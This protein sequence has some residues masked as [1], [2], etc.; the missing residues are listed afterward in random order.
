MTGPSWSM[1]SDGQSAVP[2]SEVRETRE[3][4]PP[5]PPPETEK[6]RQDSNNAAWSSYQPERPDMSERLTETTDSTAPDPSGAADD[7]SN[8]EPEA[9][10]PAELWKRS[11]GDTEGTVELRSAE[12]TPSRKETD[13]AAWGSYRPGEAAGSAGDDVA[14]VQPAEGDEI[15]AAPVEA[16]TKQPVREEAEGPSGTEEY[17]TSG[18]EGSSEGT[19]PSVGEAD[20]G[21][22][23]AQARQEVEE[24]N[25]DRPPEQEQMANDA[26]AAIDA[27]YEARDVELGKPANA[28]ALADFREPALERFQLD[29]ESRVKAT[30]LGH[31]LASELPTERWADA[32]PETRADATRRFGADLSDRLDIPR[33][34]PI[35]DDRMA[36]RE[37][38]SSQG[39]Q[40]WL[41]DRLKYE[42]DPTDMIETLAHESRHQWQDAVLKGTL[43]HPTGD[44]GLTKMVEGNIFYQSDYRNSDWTYAANYREV[45][46]EAF[47]RAVSR[48]YNEHRH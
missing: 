39:D 10:A 15:P 31:Q 27:A 45:D 33:T 5:P 2:S 17:E 40:I 32:G 28:E 8:L 6:L 24:A 38:G 1:P 13:D 21:E 18:A 4:E 3:E 14:V 41:N 34:T 42:S 44:Q 26:R 22:R 47:A 12:R 19:R 9:S 16:D 43:D 37:L 36:A 11:D 20:R 35:F 48:A 46:A 7:E 25:N 30:E 23:I 29:D